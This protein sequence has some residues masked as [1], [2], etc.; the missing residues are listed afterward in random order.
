[1]DK[2]H[3]CRETS[4]S[5]PGVLSLRADRSWDM[6]Q[7][8]GVVGD[9]G[10]QVG[11]V[12]VEDVLQMVSIDN[13]NVCVFIVDDVQS[14]LVLLV[15]DLFVNLHVCQ[16]ELYT[17]HSVVATSEMEGCVAVSIGGIGREARVEEELQKI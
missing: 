11:E 4:G 8:V 7:A 17:L 15:A 3:H 9:E 5:F 10:L 12:S 13:G 14:G 6:Q 1:M 16:Q 2:F